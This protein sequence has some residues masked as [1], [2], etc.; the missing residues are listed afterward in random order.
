MPDVTITRFVR[1]DLHKHF[2]VVAAVDAQQ[3]ILLKPTRRI[4][5]DTF[6]PGPQDAVVLEATGR[7]VAQKKNV[8]HAPGCA[9][10]AARCC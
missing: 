3:Q 9:R 7:L 2:V 5:L 4:D 8:T 1:I 10:R 6:P